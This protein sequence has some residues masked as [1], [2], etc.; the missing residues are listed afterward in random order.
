LL[1]FIPE[2]AMAAKK[3]FY[4]FYYKDDSSRIQQVIQMGVVEGQ[5]MLSGQKWEE[6]KKKGDAAVKKWIDDQMKGKNCLVV[7]VGTNTSKRP[8]VDYEIKKA[9]GAK[10]GVVGI[11]I[12]GLKDLNSQQTS[13]RGGSPFAN[14]NLNGNPFGNIVTLYDPPGGDSK[15][16]YASINNN[17][18]KLIEDAIKIRA[19]Y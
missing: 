13:A 9:W 6:V 14:L 5:A 8:W 16:V 3:V 18:E 1:F 17:I 11:R 2:L 4:S 12:N 15:A 10:L 7:L 19:K